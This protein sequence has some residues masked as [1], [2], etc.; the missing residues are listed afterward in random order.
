MSGNYQSGYGQKQ[1]YD[2]LSSW[3]F[4]NT[5]QLILTFGVFG[6]YVYILIA[7]I[8]DAVNDSTG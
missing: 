6:F 4:W 1:W 5:G 7:I 8:I 3:L 2:D